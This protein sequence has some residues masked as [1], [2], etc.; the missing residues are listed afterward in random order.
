MLHDYEV[1]GPIQNINVSAAGISLAQDF[2][3][4]IPSPILAQLKCDARSGDLLK[5]LQSIMLESIQE[6][7]PS[8][9]GPSMS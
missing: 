1:R 8:I 9:D 3:E 6:A 7:E 5:R 2:M 4:T